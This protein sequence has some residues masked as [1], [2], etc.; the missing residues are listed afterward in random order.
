LRAPLNNL[1]HWLNPLYKHNED[2]DV[3]NHLHQQAIDQG[4]IT[5]GTLSSYIS[6]PIVMLFQMP[7]CQ[8]IPQVRNVIQ[9]LGLGYS[10]QADAG[11]G[12][13]LLLD[14]WAIL[15]QF[16]PHCPFFYFL[17]MPQSWAGQSKLYSENK[18]TAAQ[19]C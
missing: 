18:A 19:C 13:I 7:T 5:F 17:N 6:P 8:S 16:V 3:L 1:L 10:A 11:F 2:L 14:F 4:Y 12:A 15:I 9:L